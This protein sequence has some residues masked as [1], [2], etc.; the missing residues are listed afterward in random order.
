MARQLR[1]TGTFIEHF[2]DI[3]DQRIHNHNY[4]HKLSDIFVI[5]I[6]AMICGADGWVEIKT[7]HKILQVRTSIAS[8]QW[9]QDWNN[10]KQQ[11]FKKAA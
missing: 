9:I 7:A 5:T 4:R 1:L 6:L 8:N 2:T 11:I 10:A 3:E